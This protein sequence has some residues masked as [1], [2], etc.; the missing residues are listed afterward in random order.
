M[1]ERN[2][3]TIS[4]YGKKL[5]NEDTHEAYI[6]RKLANILER[7][8]IL[9]DKVVNIEKELRTDGEKELG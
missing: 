6:D 8:K 9:E 5:L 1:E 7:L 2:G 3:N 4:E